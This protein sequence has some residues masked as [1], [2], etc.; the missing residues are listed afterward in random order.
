MN[1]YRLVP[2]DQTPP[3]H[4]TVPAQWPKKELIDLFPPR[5]E[6]KARLLLTHLKGK[7][8]I[9][10]DNRVIYLDNGQEEEGGPVYDLIKF[11]ISPTPPNG[12]GQTRP[13]DAFKFGLLLRAANVPISAYGSN[14]RDFVDNITN[15]ANNAD[16]SVNSGHSG[17]NA[18][19]WKRLY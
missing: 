8:R 10:D 9:T 4:L 15:N 19:T 2:A 1:K 5:L 11:Y 7:I 13:P 3:T 17:H 18:Y 6:N 12:T 14:K 16:D